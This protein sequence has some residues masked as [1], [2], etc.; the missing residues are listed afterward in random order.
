[1][2]RSEFKK[3]V[4]DA[5]AGIP[6]EFLNAL[7]N[8]AVTVE[9]APSPRIARQLGLK[10]HDILLGLYQGVPLTGRDTGYGNVLPDKITL[11]QKQIEE[12]YA[13]PEEIRKAVRE[14][15][16]HEIAHYFGIGEERLRDLGIG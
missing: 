4:K 1:M 14:T 7:E 3:L 11:Y 16:V 15:V 10:K 6:E 9:D 8:I 5:L 13:T 12:L 2:K